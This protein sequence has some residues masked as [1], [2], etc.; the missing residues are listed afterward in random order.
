MNKYKINWNQAPSKQQQFLQDFLYPFWKDKIVLSE[1][2]IPG[3]NCLLRID[4]FNYS[5]KQAIE[6]SPKSH[7]GTFK[8]TNTKT[9][10]T[11][12]EH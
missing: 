10:E 6:F 3:R 9:G 12:S 1:F 5:G 11:L 8:K 7:H 2:K 4:L